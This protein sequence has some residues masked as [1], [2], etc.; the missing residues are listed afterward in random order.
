MST[1]SFQDY[2]RERM[3]RKR[4]EA[5]TGVRDP[6][7]AAP[8]ASARTDPSRP[9][10]RPMVP[11]QR[12]NAPPPGRGGAGP[13]PAAAF[14]HPHPRPPAW[15][16]S[17]AP[18]PGSCAACGQP[19][20][21]HAV[22]LNALKDMIEER[23][24]TLAWLGSSKQNPIQ[25]NLMLKLIRSG[26][27]P[28]MAR[29]VLERVPA[30]ARAAEAVR[31]VMDVITRNL[32]VAAPGARPVRR[33]RRGFADR[34]HRCG[35]DHHRRQAGRPVRQ[36]VRRRQRGPDHAGQLPRLGLR[37]AARLRPHAGRGGPPGARP[38]RA[39]RPAQPAGEQA[40][41]HHRHRRSGPAR[42]AHPGHA[43]R[44]GR[45]QR[46]EGAGAQRRR[47]RRHAGRRAHHVQVQLAARRG[48]L[49]GGRSRQARPGDR[50]ADPPP[51]GAARRGQR[52][53]RAR[54]LAGPRRGG[55][56]AHV[57]GQS[58]ASRPTTRC[59][60]TSASTSR[61]PPPAASTSGVPRSEAPMFDIGFDQ[62]AGLRSASP[63]TAPA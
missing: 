23:F 31:W 2:V 59:P 5:L 32:K 41:G 42:P 30:D 44:A 17:A 25:S 12:F 60:P 61:K 9:R 11:V 54:R 58:K 29:A 22:E 49:Q 28:A 10:A 6:V 21:A 52:P 15:E 33:R 20:R 38:R 39:H 36:A 1:L 51:G 4:R 16:D 3:L 50:R 57:H 46:E 47:A 43:R 40:P 8:A 18:Q 14:P 24:N 7:L 56:G 26:Y 34:R 53:A 19:Q 35:Q 55:P 62:A 48:A 13:G 27:S 45:A 63:A 37:A